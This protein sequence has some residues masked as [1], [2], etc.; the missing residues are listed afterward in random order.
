MDMNEK[1]EK[2]NKIEQ[3][4][5]K[6]MQI[7]ECICNN[8]LYFICDKCIKNKQSIQNNCELFNYECGDNIDKDIKIGTILLLGRK[9]GFKNE[10]V[11]H[12]VYKI[13]EDTFNTEKLDDISY[14]SLC[15][16]DNKTLELAS[17]NYKI[18]G[19]ANT[20][21]G[22]ETLKK[23][24]FLQDKLNNLVD[25]LETIDVLEIDKILNKYGEGNAI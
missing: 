18:I 5:S 4:K 9:D 20:V 6:I 19:L 11:L 7:S 10:L 17:G 23:Q 22:I 21:A 14:S 24:C 12:K 13:H 25:K 16:F 8:C 15:V 1:L 2:F 3:D